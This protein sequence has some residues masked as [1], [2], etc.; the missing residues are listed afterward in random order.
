MS[1]Q[2]FLVA[3]CSL[4]AALCGGLFY[5]RYW[6]WRDCIRE[7]HAGCVTPDGQNLTTG[8]MLWG[9]LALVLAGAAL[10]VFLRR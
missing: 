9:F 6:K 7:A 1:A 4:L 8:G 10:R 2:R 3:G 5:F